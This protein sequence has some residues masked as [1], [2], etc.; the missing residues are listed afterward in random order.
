MGACA[1]FGSA[2]MGASTVTEKY[3]THPRDILDF[4]LIFFLHN[5]L[6]KP[7]NIDSTVDA[8]ISALPNSAQAPISAQF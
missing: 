8:P 7:S 3:S 2:L 4:P 6:V 5:M 1:L